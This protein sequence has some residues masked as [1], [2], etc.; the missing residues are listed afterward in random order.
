M[1]IIS[2]EMIRDAALANGR[3]DARDHVPRRPAA[4]GSG[5]SPGDLAAESV[6]RHILT[7]TPANLARSEVC[8]RALSALFRLPPQSRLEILVELILRAPWRYGAL[9]DAVDGAVRAGAITPVAELSRVVLLHDI[10]SL[11]RRQRIERLLRHA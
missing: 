8:E 6:L 5:S 3:T 2:Q 11:D 1:D 4:P 10:L 9:I 7:L